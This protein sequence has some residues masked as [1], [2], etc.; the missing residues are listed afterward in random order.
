MLTQDELN[1]LA[2]AREIRRRTRRYVGDSVQVPLR[3]LVPADAA[4]V[5]ALYEMLGGLFGLIAPRLDGGLGSVLAVR[6]FLLATGFADLARRIDGLGATLDAGATPIELREVYHDVRG[7]GLPA[8]L[9]VLDAVASGEGVADDLERIFVLCRD[10]LKIIRNALPDLD[11]EGYA[12]DLT[13]RE[14]SSELLLAK[15]SNERYRLREVEVEVALRCDFDGTI[16]ECCMEFAA[17]D[18]VIYNLVNNAA[19]FAA[20]GR[21]ELRVFPVREGTATDL[22][23]VVINRVTPEHA[24]RVQADLGEDLSRVFNGGY[25]TGGHGLGLRI[26]GDF[27]SHGYGLPSLATALEGGY[28]GARMVR[29]CFVAWFHWPARRPA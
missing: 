10:Q 7:G 26:C 14:H 3:R 24:E 25:T 20:D 6:G 1:G 23:F 8:L 11:A 18:R 13:L 15:W 4:V 9:M 12:R 29:D 5:R 27:V 2:D 28:I 21:V 17:L 16:S 19:R 22:R